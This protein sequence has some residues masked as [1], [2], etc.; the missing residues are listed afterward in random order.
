VL[1]RLLEEPRFQIDGVSATS[2][3]AMNA[4]VLAHGLTVGGRRAAKEALANFWR[5][6]SKAAS[7]SMVQPSWFDRLANNHSLER[8]P[9]YVFFDYLTRVLS[10][11]QFNPLN[12]N[13]LKSIL[14]E[15][16]DFEE[17]RAQ[18]AIKLF[19]CATNV[20]TGKARVFTNDEICVMRVLASA[21][22]PFISQA[23][24]IDGQHYCLPVTLTAAGY[25]E[26]RREAGPYP[27]PEATN[28][29]NPAALSPSLSLRS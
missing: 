13:P 6:L 15:V 11:Y 28:S 26:A 23:V 17:L 5:K 4:V 9:G 8:S 22:L 21:C 12:Y 27:M 20:R 19:V 2:A 24:E 29:R 14:Q 1:D 3:G 18:S 7:Q 25:I 10:P 16:V